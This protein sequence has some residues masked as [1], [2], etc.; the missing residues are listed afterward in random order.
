MRL[1]AVI[2]LAVT[3]V[4]VYF[5]FIDKESIKYREAIVKREPF[6]LKIS[7]YGTLEASNFVQIKSS[8]MGQ[9]KLIEIIPEGSRVEKG[10]IVAR[11]D[12]TTLMDSMNDLIFRIN[13]SEAIL[14]KNKKELE[15]FKRES[16][17]AIEKIKKSI[18]IAKINIRDEKFGSGKVKE[19]E[20]KHSIIK[21]RRELE[22]VREELSD[23]NSL[24]KKGYISK[25]ERDKIENGFKD[26]KESLEILKEK[27][28]NY[29][30]YE[31]TKGISEKEIKL[32]ELKEELESKKVQNSFE[33]D[34][35]KIQVSKAKNSLLQYGKR[36]E[37]VKKD[38]TLCDV[39]TP[40]DG[41]ALYKNISRSADKRKYIEI[42]DTLWQSQAFIQIPNTDKMIVKT[43]TREVDLN[44]V[45]VGMSVEVYLDAYPKKVLYGI[46]TY[47]DTIAD[48]TEKD[49]YIKKFKTII[50][51]KNTEG[52]LRSGM[53]A[54]VDIVYDEVKDSLTIPI[55][56]LHYNQ[57]K[58][59]IYV[60]NGK[61]GERREIE[62]GRM[63][64]KY[65]E[66]KKGLKEKEVVLIR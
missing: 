66:I 58:Y 44:K 1:L 2:F 14:A 28:K 48:S 65:I 37:K 4:L 9:V 22:L 42:G 57:E 11:F 8:I 43:Y 3:V 21:G 13:Q 54:R 51:I 63:G 36:L 32:K 30:K 7:T 15:V 55:D 59:F 62:I 53:S 12:I 39:R 20:F 10:Q 60:D 24:F 23:F 38:I 18:Q 61:D 35:R 56:A 25:R 41:I 29:R 64:T 19:N 5:L 46:I 33:L 16:K 52:F 17:D 49:K 6:K 26:T 31:W 34:N 45:K 40:I 50:T 27:L 47:I